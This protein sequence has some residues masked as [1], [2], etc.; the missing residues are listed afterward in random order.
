M[1]A[2]ADWDELRAAVDEVYP[3]FTDRLY[4]LYPNLSPHE[5][6]ICLLIKIEMPGK[7][8]AKLL[9]VSPSA[10]TQARKRLYKKINGEAGIGES[11]DKIILDL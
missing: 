9:N 3:H 7:A 10:I 1:P 8:M 5:W 2:S 6:H 4:A 11:F